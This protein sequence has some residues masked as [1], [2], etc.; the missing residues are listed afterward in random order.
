MQAKKAN[1]ILTMLIPGKYQPKNMKV[2]LQPLLDELDIL[3]RTSVRVRDSSQ[4]T[5]ELFQVK[6]VNL[7]TI[8]DSPGLQL[9]FG[10]YN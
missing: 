3:W 2:Y 9:C 6:V 5:E 10:E 1:L 4:S 7:W 8:T